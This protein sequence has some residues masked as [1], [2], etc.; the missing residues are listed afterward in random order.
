MPIRNG[1]HND[2]TFFGKQGAVIG[3]FFSASG[4]IG[5]T[6]NP[7]QYRTFAFPGRCIDAQEM[8]ILRLCK[9]IMATH[10]ETQ[11]ERILGTSGKGSPAFHGS[12]KRFKD[13]IFE[14]SRPGIYR[15]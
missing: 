10:Q 5:S 2:I 7:H 4:Q 12:C 14:P 6:V 15:M 1:H 11:T 13:R 3:R 9:F 8:A